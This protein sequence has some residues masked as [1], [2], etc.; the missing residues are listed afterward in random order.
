MFTLSNNGNGLNYGTDH[1]YTEGVKN[2]LKPD[3]LFTKELEKEV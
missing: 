3:K 1:L 2:I